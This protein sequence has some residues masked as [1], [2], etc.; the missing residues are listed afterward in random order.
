V[1]VVFI[2]FNGIMFKLSGKSYLILR[3]MVYGCR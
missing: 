1:F 3:N 2:E